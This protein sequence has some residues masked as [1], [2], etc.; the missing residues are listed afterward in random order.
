[1][2]VYCS[3]ELLRHGLRIVAFWMLEEPWKKFDY[4]AG[5]FYLL[6]VPCRKIFPTLGRSGEEQMMIDRVQ[7]I[8]NFN[9]IRSK[10]SWVFYRWFEELPLIKIHLR[11]G[12]SGSIVVCS[13]SPLRTPWNRHELLYNLLKEFGV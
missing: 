8:N 9:I 13:S 2:E 7:N 4:H 11:M 5:F 12:Y 10:G 1:M 6:Y 3:P